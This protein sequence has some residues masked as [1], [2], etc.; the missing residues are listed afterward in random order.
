MGRTLKDSFVNLIEY[1]TYRKEKDREFCVPCPFLLFC[2][3][4]F[5]C[6]NIFF[7][8]LNIKF[9]KTKQKVITL[10]AAT[11]KALL[12]ITK[13]NCRFSR[14][15]FNTGNVYNLFLNVLI[16]IFPHQHIKKVRNRGYAPKNASSDCCYTKPDRWDNGIRHTACQ[17][18]RFYQIQKQYA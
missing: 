13:A 7:F 5:T 9:R 18:L 6:S 11:L 16:H 3:I 8:D 2:S 1:V 14:R 12:A 17:N 15:K 4:I 10:V